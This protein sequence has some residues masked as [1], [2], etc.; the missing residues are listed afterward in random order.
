MS[1]APNITEILFALGLSDKIVAVSNDS[2]Y[3]LEAAGINKVGTF[4]QPST[5]S[6]ISTK[7]DLVVTLWFAQQKSVADT[8]EQL[9]Y[10]V[11]V[12]RMDKFRDLPEAIQQIGIATG[13]KEQAEKLTNLLR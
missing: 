12:L 3:P 8:L 1:L 10:N 4:W 2:D 5:E 13:A 11:L 7:P 6:I 9:G